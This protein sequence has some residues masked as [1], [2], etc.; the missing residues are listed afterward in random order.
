M[1]L[2]LLEK[3]QEN[4][5]IFPN[6][7][8]NVT[9]SGNITEVVTALPERKNKIK[10]LNAEE[11]KSYNL[12]ADK[13]YYMTIPDGEINECRVME[14]RHD[15]YSGV[16]QS[17][18]RLRGYINANVVNADRCRWIT[19]TYRQ[20]ESEDS[21]AVPMTDTKRL[22]LDFKH[23][24]QRIRRHFWN[25]NIEYICVAE[26]QGSGAWHMHVIL[27]F[28][29]KAPFIPNDV[30]REKF[31]KKGFVDIQR[32]DDNCDNL[33]AYFSAYLCNIEYKEGDPLDPGDE[34]ID[35]LDG[36]GRGKKYI[37][38][39]RLKFYPPKFNL[40]RLSK[41]VEAPIEEQMLYK[42]LDKSKLGALTAAR[43]V[44]LY[45]EETGAVITYKYEYYNKKR[46]PDVQD[47]Y[48]ENLRQRLRDFQR[49]KK[50]A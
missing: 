45:D 10:I 35:D 31:W 14:S 4:V 13:K 7:T 47:R 6:E 19:L 37:K 21:E 36:K 49:G 2:Q 17:I 8:V 1:K 12:D 5:F 20:R 15:D 50:I 43:K 33:G 18:N 40:Y 48:L 30:L 22:Y 38:G 42:K 34:I 28:S 26:P 46:E 29:K 27:I 24:M 25:R 16:K 23:F 44:S 32:L 9:F 41:G 3:T 39:G 11:V